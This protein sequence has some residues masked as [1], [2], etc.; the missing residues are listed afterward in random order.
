MFVSDPVSG[1]VCCP[2]LA[3]RVPGE[4]GLLGQGPGL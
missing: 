3:H 4:E 1:P 2:R